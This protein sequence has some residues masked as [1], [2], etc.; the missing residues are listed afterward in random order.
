MRTRRITWTMTVILAVALLGTTL[1]Q[2]N[3]ETPET[4]A[5][6]FLRIKAVGDTVPG[7]NYPTNRV[8]ANPRATLF[9]GVE[10]Y[11][12]GADITFANFEST[13]TNISNTYKDVSRKNTY[14]FRTPVSM[15]KILRDVGFDVLGLAN[16]HSGDFTPAGYIDTAKNVRAAGMTA[17]ANDIEYVTRNGQK[18]AFIAFSYLGAHNSIHNIPRAKELV[19]KAVAGADIVIVTFHGGAEG[20]KYTHVPRVNEMFLGESRGNLPAFSHAVIDAGADLVI[21]HGPHVP[22]AMELYRD[23]LIAYSLGNFIGYGALSARGI[24]GY[25]LILDVTLNRDGSFHSG[26]IIPLINSTSAIPGYDSQKRSIDLV[27]RLSV[28]DFPSSPLAI[29]P[30]GKLSRK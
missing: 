11:L 4:G 15:G 21:G 26:E 14:A 10:P 19:A 18:I 9:A 3:E 8:P 29:S 25:S 1:V 6:K 20:G 5:T 28:E 12:K 23:R 30:A 27:R 7:T 16:N 22:R 17:V 2:A 24:A 13:L